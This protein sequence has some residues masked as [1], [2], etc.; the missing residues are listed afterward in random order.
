MPLT[1]RPSSHLHRRT[2]ACAFPLLEVFLPSSQQVNNKF[3][4]SCSPAGWVDHA[5][6]EVPLG[7]GG[8]GH[9]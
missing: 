9:G 8:T 6:L 7:S 3:S 4:P 5:R 2:V 1:L